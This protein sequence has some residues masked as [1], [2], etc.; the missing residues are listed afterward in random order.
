MIEIMTKKKNGT[1][2]FSIKDFSGLKPLA[3]VLKDLAAKIPLTKAVNPTSKEK[4]N[5]TPIYFTDALFDLIMSLDQ[6]SQNLLRAELRMPKSGSSDQR[7]WPTWVA[8]A[9]DRICFSEESL[10]GGEIR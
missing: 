1:K 3:V 7:R 6:N 9:C 10:N 4:E 5:D 2:K 8:E